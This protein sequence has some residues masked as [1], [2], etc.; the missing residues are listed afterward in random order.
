MARPSSRRWRKSH[1]NAGIPP[2]VC[3]PRVSDSRRLGRREGGARRFALR[4]RRHRTSARRT[5]PEDEPKERLQCVGKQRGNAAKR[6]INLARRL[7]RVSFDKLQSHDAKLMR[8]Y[9]AVENGVADLADPRLKD[10]VA[11]LTAIREQSPQ[12][13]PRGGRNRKSGPTLTPQARCNSPDR[14]ENGC[15]TPK[16]ATGATICGRRSG[17]RSTSGKSASWDR[18]RHCSEPSSPHLAGK[19]REWAFPSFVPKW[20]AQGDS[21]PCFRRERATS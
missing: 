7:L 14:R 11:E 12:R 17:S 6:S 15:V 10:R 8:L 3:A 18:K 16:A 20:R 2:L 21:N 1:S 9:E 13:R 4:L 5:P 19:R